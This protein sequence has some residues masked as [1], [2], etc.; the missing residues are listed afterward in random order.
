M[1]VT[2][3]K[4]GVRYLK[5]FSSLEGL[6]RTDPEIQTALQS[7]VVRKVRCFA[8]GPK[9][10]NILQACQRCIDRMGIRHKAVVELGDTPEECLEKAR[11]VVGREVAIFWTC[12]VYFGLKELFFQNPD[13][14]PFF[15]TEVMRLDKM[16]LVTRQDIIDSFEG[17]PWEFWPSEWWQEVR[18]ASHPSPAPLLEGFIPDEAIVKANSNAHAA[19]LCAV[20]RSVEVC[21]TTERSRDLYDLKELHSFG[22]P[23]MLFFGGITGHGANI[24]RGAHEYETPLSC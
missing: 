6:P 12:A 5:T 16:Q 23:E 17:V 19:E 2:D 22:S 18:V 20:E 9:G 14:Y 24:I 8:L 15:I 4:T 21:I 7:Q 10:T 3:N 13:V 11:G 1:S